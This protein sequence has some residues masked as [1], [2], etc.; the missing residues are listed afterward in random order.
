MV[1][2]HYAGVPAR[3]VIAFAEL[4]NELEMQHVEMF[5]DS[6][7]SA[8]VTNVKAADLKGQRVS[9]RGLSRVIGLQPSTIRRR[10]AQLVEQGW[11]AQDATGVHFPDAARE[12]GA[13]KA[14]KAMLR[15]AQVLKQLGW[16]DFR[17]P[18]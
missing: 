17:P 14:R 6:I 7:N 16:G 15:F 8:I 13:P 10:I 2:E 5:G 1:Q 18:D 4:M 12:R 3:E 9:V 11:L